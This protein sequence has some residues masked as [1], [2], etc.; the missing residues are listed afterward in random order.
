MLE[1]SFILLLALKVE[2]GK[3]QL[4]TYGDNYNNNSS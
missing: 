2:M 1:I 4:K 3:W